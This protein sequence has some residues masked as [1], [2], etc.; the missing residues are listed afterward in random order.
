MPQYAIFM[1]PN[2]VL[3]TYKKRFSMHPQTFHITAFLIDSEQ[4]L[5]E[6]QLCH[7]WSDGLVAY[8]D[9]L[10]FSQ[11]AVTLHNVVRFKKI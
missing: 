1:V 6:R 3:K 10:R 8:Y 4:L 9:W 5:L 7:D 2:F 11:S